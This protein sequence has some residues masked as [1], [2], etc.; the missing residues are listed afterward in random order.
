M[1][2]VKLVVSTIRTH[3]Q[4][5]L[6]LWEMWI[7]RKRRKK[8]NKKRVQLA[9]NNDLYF[10]SPT[11]IFGIPMKMVSNASLSSWISCNTVS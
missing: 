9:S 5:N 1:S 8:K 3:L 4:V 10:L 6:V 7:Q 2:L 11:E